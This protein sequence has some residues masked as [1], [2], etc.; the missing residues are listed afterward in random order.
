MLRYTIHNPGRRRFAI[1]HEFNSRCWKQHGSLTAQE[2]LRNP[3]LRVRGCVR[4]ESIGTAVLWIQRDAIKYDLRVR[5][6]NALTGLD[7]PQ[8]RNNSAFFSGD[9]HIEFKPDEHAGGRGESAPAKLVENDISRCPGIVVLWTPDLSRLN[10]HV[11][12]KCPQGAYF[13]V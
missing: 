12:R 1:D 10:N 7:P 13:T 8:P 4:A 5:A 6:G 11:H 3:Q 9:S 2:V